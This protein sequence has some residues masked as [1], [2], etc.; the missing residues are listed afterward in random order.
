MTTGVLLINLGTPNS[1]SVKDVR[2]YLR[3]FLSDPYVIDTN[4]FVRFLLLNLII[5]PTRPKQSAKAY[6]SIW[7]EDGSP[8]LTNSVA[9][10]ENAQQLL[11]QQFN[12]A[13]AMRYGK[14]SIKNAVASLKHCD[15]IIILPL[16]PQ[17][18][19]AATETAIVKALAF[20]KPHWLP[21][22]ISIIKD[23]YNN[24]EYINAQAQLIESAFTVE[25]NQDRMILFSY[26]GLPERQILK[27]SSCNTVCNM[28]QVCPVIS[29]KNRDCYRAQCY[30]TSRA[31][32]AKLQ[33]SSEQY[34]TTFQS[35]LGRIPWIK[36]YTD[37]VLN[38]LAQKGIKHLIVAC[39][40]FVCDCLETLEEIGLRAREQWLAAGGT[41]L[42]LV[43]CVNE[44]ANWIHSLIQK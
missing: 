29:D 9:L 37:V 24:A 32:A 33:L 5:L 34:T 19:L 8:L 21:E 15:D 38:E 4:S 26:H 11:G 14:P 44:D 39:P 31:L 23:F 36:P 30:E 3:E 1:P 13:L 12:V 20:V 41:S 2:R 18:S 43:P 6:Q 25:N 27:T 17:Y 16:F 10:S 28:Q 7:Q 22:K 35:R 40:S 42:T